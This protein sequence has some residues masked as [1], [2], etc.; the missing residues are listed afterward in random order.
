M[1][2]KETLNTADYLLLANIVGATVK[3]FEERLDPND[4]KSKEILE[5]MNELHSKL[6]RI[7]S[8]NTPNVSDIIKKMNKGK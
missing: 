8:Q 1:K 4:E 2:E 7:N 6:K 3:D 5:V